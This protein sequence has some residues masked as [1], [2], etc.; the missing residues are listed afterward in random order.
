MR[1]EGPQVEGEPGREA[2]EA[3]RSRFLD[4]D[5]SRWDLGDHTLSLDGPRVM[6]IVNLT[7]DS[8]SDGGQ[9]ST[10]ET[11]L[12]RARQLVRE[13][14]DVLDV[15]GESTRPG[16]EAVSAEEEKRRILPF[17]EAAVEA[18]EVP[19]S[20][21]TRNASVA[22]EALSAG[23]R[24]V[25]DVSG[26]KHDEDMA[27]AVA[28]GEG[29]L[30]L[31]HMRG[32]PASM[33][34]LAKYQDVA[35]EVK[36]ELAQ[37]LTR[38]RDAGIRED[39]I[40]LDPGIGFAKTGPQSLAIM[41]RLGVLL[42]LGFPLLVGPSRK[43][44]IGELTGAPPHDRTPGTLAACVFCYFQGARIFRVHDVAPLVQALAVTRAL[45]E[46]SE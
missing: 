32:T 31:S 29:G 42:A 18:F 24:I 28:E 34:A 30:V 38:A 1:S 2:H 15:G 33:R 10:L 44:F 35:V 46:A 11:A 26:L 13:G 45:G 41:G 7:P 27:R 8:F 22:R 16:A 25:N 12:D 4:S 5:N 3:F 21:D 20:V 40:V 39:R 9:L 17:I 36:E 37:S 19:I 14:A 6:G 43:S 23:A